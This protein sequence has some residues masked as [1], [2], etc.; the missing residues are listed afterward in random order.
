MFKGVNTDVITFTEGALL[1]AWLVM[2]LIAAHLYWLSRLMT[3][4][5]V[6]F[7]ALLNL[8]LQVGAH[9]NALDHD[10]VVALDR[11]VRL[12]EY[13]LADF[14]PYTPEHPAFLAW[15]EDCDVVVAYTETPDGFITVATEVYANAVKRGGEPSRK[16]ELDTTFPFEDAEE[17]LREFPACLAPT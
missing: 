8:V 16:L 15:I 3:P 5:G 12:A 13:V 7:F 10:K 1:V 9:V 11:Q 2:L 14:S 17:F 6:G 4:I